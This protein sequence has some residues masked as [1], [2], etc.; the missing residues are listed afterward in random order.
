[1]DEIKIFQKLLWINK[2]KWMLYDQLNIAMY[3][4]YL[5][6]IYLSSVHAYAEKHSSVYLVKLYVT[7]LK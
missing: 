5:V 1:M 6:K 3:F 7:G 4:W 2:L